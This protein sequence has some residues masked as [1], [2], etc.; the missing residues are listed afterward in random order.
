ME[1]LEQQ[2]RK[3]SADQQAQLLIVVQALHAGHR[4]EVVK[5]HAFEPGSAEWNEQI[6]RLA[7]L[8]QPEYPNV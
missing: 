8:V 3:L 2:V 1:S 5:L 7:R 6:S 4:A